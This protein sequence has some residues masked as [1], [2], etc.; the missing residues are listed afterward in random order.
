MSLK[1]YEIE[2][3]ENE[4]KFI[5]EFMGLQG[6][7]LTFERSHST[8]IYAVWLTKQIEVLPNKEEPS[9]IID[10]MYE[11]A[12]PL[13]NSRLTASVT[14]PLQKEI[15]TLKEEVKRLEKLTESLSEAFTNGLE[16]L[17]RE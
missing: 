17:E 2:G 12:G 13:R 11:L 5:A 1:H 14:A 15:E 8:G 16:Y 10:S 7:G 3:L 6:F 9:D 4:L